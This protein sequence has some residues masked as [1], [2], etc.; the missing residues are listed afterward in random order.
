M[1]RLSKY[2]RQYIFI[3]FVIYF[4]TILL[5][6]LI[7]FLLILIE[8]YF[9]IVTICACTIGEFVLD[10]LNSFSKPLRSILPNLTD[11]E[12]YLILVNTIITTFAFIY[13]YLFCK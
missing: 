1:I 6:F 11:D 4:L 7:Y 13:A 3:T 8:K 5:S 12:Y 2:I 10:G 9:P